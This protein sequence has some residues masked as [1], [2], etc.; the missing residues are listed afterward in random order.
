MDEKCIM[1]LFLPGAQVLL[2]KLLV[3]ALITVL[4][5]ASMFGF[6]NAN[7]AVL[8][9]V[10]ESIIT[11]KEKEI[12][13]NSSRVHSALA[14]KDQAGNAITQTTVGTQVYIEGIVN[15]D[16]NTSGGSPIALFEVRDEEDTTVYLAWQTFPIDTGQITIGSSWMP[17]K[18]GNYEERFFPITCLQC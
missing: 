17:D 5:T 7:A 15:L 8:S 12:N 18:P 1:L 2:P 16:C 11:V 4:L 3:S 14:V 9:A 6:L 13:C 10:Q